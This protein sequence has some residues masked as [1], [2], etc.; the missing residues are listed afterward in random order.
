MGGHKNTNSVGESKIDTAPWKQ[1]MSQLYSAI[2]NCNALI[3][4]A[5]ASELD[6]NF[7]DHICGEALFLRA[8]FYFD[9]VRLYGRVPLVLSSPKTLE[10]AYSPRSDINTILAQIVSDL[11]NAFEMMPDKEEQIMGRPHKW[12]AKA[13]LAKVYC[14][15]GCLKPEHFRVNA[16][17]AGIPYTEAEQKEF[18]TNAYN[19]CDEVIKSEKYAL[20]D[21]FE[22]L[23]YNKVTSRNSCESIFE[24]QFNDS[25]IETSNSVTVR[26]LTKTSEFCPYNGTSNWTSAGMC[27]TT[28]QIFKRHWTRYGQLDKSGNVIPLE[29]AFASKK[30]SSKMPDIDPRINMTYVYYSYQTVTNDKDGRFKKYKGVQTIYPNPTVKANPEDKASSD[31][32]FIPIKKHYYPDFNGAGYCNIVMFRYAEVL[33]LMAQACNEL[34]RPQEAVEY[35]DMVLRRA[36]RY[37]EGGMM[38]SVSDKSWTPQTTPAVYG[39]IYSDPYAT[40]IDDP[41]DRRSPKLLSPKL[42][43]GLEHLDNKDT[44]R[45]R[46]Q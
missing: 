2:G 5:Q 41:D 29:I 26:Q 10:E 34:D 18:W 44:L 14:Y 33:L 27:R 36:K 7:V 32:Y 9:L 43:A 46:I 1:S 15:M 19:C 25:N 28:P 3:E 4:N 40:I 22:D 35:V 11:Q 13:M 16:D 38:T 30:A 24:Y 20:V 21:C 8:F 31:W 12:A 17:N 39:N 42:A 23:F 6:K 37:R 45:L